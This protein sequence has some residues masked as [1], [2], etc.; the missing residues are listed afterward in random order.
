MRD[1]GAALQPVDAAEAGDDLV[2]V[3]P[4][5]VRL[6][7]GIED[8]D[9]GHHQD[10]RADDRLDDIAAHALSHRCAQPGRHAS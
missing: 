9:A 10:Q 1:V 7:E 8:E 5:A 6:G 2:A 4:G 3:R